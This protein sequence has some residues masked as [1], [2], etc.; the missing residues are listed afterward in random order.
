MVVRRSGV[1]WAARRNRELAFPGQAVTESQVVDLEFLEPGLV[2]ATPA[3]EPNT[4]T[5]EEDQAGVRKFCDSAKRFAGIKRRGK[6]PGR[7]GVGAECDSQVIAV[8]DLNQH[9]QWLS[10]V[11]QQAT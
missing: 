4:A 9:P 5:S 10:T 2:A 11:R 3:L 6:D 7:L 8:G 1:F